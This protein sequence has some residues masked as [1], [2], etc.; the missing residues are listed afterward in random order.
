MVNAEPRL[1]STLPNIS[2]PP[3]CARAR[4]GFLS[5][6]QRVSVLAGAQ[7]VRVWG[8]VCVCSVSVSAHVGGWQPATWRLRSGLALSGRSG[9]VGGR[10]QQVCTHFSFNLALFSPLTPKRV[11]SLAL[12]SISRLTFFK[13]LLFEKDPDGNRLLVR[14]L[15]SAFDDW[16]CR[17]DN[18]S[19]V[20]P[21][22]TP[23]HSS[24]RPINVQRY[25]R[26]K[27]EDTVIGGIVSF[28][29]V[30][31][32]FRVWRQLS[33]RCRNSLGSIWYLVFRD[34]YQINRAERRGGKQFTLKICRGRSLTPQSTFIILHFQRR[35]VKFMF[36]K[37]SVQEK[38][39]FIGWDLTRMSQMCLSLLLKHPD[40]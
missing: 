13:W 11:C 26:F 24:L 7:G 8:C 20:I 32:W 14:F 15:T 27:L 40:D 2:T 38:F 18:G 4:S 12:G 34:L 21:R 19:L 16:G 35:P 25:L 39:P 17:L 10:T 3:W 30:L 9:R 37:V 23:W 31:F 1:N 29:K 33:K 36:L 5:R 28:Y 6:L 22:K